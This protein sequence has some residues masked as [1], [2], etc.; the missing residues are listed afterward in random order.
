MTQSP[1]PTASPSPDE[2]VE[3]F[4]AVKITNPEEKQRL[5]DEMKAGIAQRLEERQTPYELEDVDF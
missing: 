1:T 4:N 2:I 5:W 3:K